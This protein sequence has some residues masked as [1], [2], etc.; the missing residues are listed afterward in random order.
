MGQ[1]AGLRPRKFVS[2][3]LRTLA[4]ESPALVFATWINDVGEIVGWG[5]DKRTD[6]VRAFLASPAKPAASAGPKAASAVRVL[7][8]SARNRL[9]DHLPYFRSRNA[10]TRRR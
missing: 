2:E 6:E 10:V 1:V 4:G 3:Q 5:V 8:V 9:Q 7:P